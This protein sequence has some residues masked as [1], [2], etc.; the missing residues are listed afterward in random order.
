MKNQRISRKGI[1]L[2][3]EF[4]GW[5]A[6]PYWDAL[7]QVWTQGWGHTA[8]VSRHDAPWTLEQGEAMLLQ[9]LAESESI[10]NS[11]NLVLTQNQFDALVSFVF[12]VGPGQEGVKDGLIWLKSGGTSTMPR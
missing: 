12:N 1:K 11:L 9:D 6:E 2:V 7:G 5:R 8:N 4:E 10:V 3:K